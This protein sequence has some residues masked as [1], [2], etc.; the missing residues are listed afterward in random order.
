MTAN[1]FTAAGVELH[2]FAD[3]VPLLQMESVL[4]RSI[5]VEAQLNLPAMCEIELV[6]PEQILLEASGLVPGS[7]IE[8]RAVAPS[9]PVGMPLFAGQI[10]S[11]E[12]RF[13]VSTGLRS[14]V[15]AYDQGHWMLHGQNTRGYPMMSY[16]D[17]VE[18]IGLEHGVLTEATPTPVIYPM[19]VQSNETDWDFMVRLGREIGYVTQVALDPIVGVPTLTF[20]PVSPAEE[21]PPP[22]GAEISPTAIVVGDDGLI[23]LR[24][25][26]TAAGL[27]S[28]AST[29]GWDQTLAAPGVG[30]GPTMDDSSINLLP[31]IELGAEFGGANQVVSL[32]RIA[33]NEAATEAASEGLAMR[34]AGAYANVEIELRGNPFVRPNVALSISKAGLLTGDYTV[35]TA[36]HVY[37]PSGMGYRTHVVCS[38]HEDR[39][40]MGLQDAASKSTKLTGVYPAIVTDVEDPEMLGRVLLSFPWLSETFVSN[41]A[42]VVQQGASAEMGWQ[43]MPEPLDEVL[44]CFENGQL[45]SPY[46]LGGLYS[47]E[48]QGAINAEELIQGV[49][50]MRAYTSRDGHQ[51]IF[52]DSPELSSIMLQ[53][54]FGASCIIRMS[55]ETGITIETVEG[56]PITINSAS[57]VTVSAEGTVVLNAAEIT[58]N[59][60]G[61]VSISAEGAVSV[62]ASE[63]NLASDGAVTIEADVISMEAGEINI[64]GGIVTL[65]A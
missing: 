46:V 53:T 62:E 57:E 15:R 10:D 30:E 12:V 43:I 52:N 61:A 5:T 41:W 47:V 8:I 23:S 55:P 21:A 42:R 26:A 28:V 14:I 48:R 58:L 36:M 39:S 31:A 27:T 54:T 33:E 56:Q 11:V 44:V 13:D 6:D 4:L 50:M 32:D 63:I 19:I 24:A 22:I 17:V 34:L 18:M 38:G 49:P 3:G 65:G 37:E 29:R 64:A 45:D 60:E 59:G 9:D 1:P 2:V 51:L 20:G 35:T 25:T 7:M 40:L 16:S